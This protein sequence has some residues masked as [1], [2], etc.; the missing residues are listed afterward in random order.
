ME[1]VQNLSIQNQR[2]RKRNER[3][4]ENKNQMLE[5]DA[6]SLHFTS[7]PVHANTLLTVKIILYILISYKLQVGKK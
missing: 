7:N 3:G 4:K 6:Y 1:I 5:N 2:L